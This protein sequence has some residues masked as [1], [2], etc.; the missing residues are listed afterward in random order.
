MIKNNKKALLFTTALLSLSLFLG[1]GCTNKNAQQNP[2]ANNTDTAKEKVQESKGQVNETSQ[3]LT[4]RAQKIAD[5]V[6]KIDG[7]DKAR[8]AISEK[9]AL[10][11]VTIPN[12]AEGKLTDDLKKKVEDTV[13]NTDKEIDTVAVSADADIYERISKIGDGIKDGRGIEEFGNE[14]K[15]LFNRI[16]PQ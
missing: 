2:P 11:G 15:E 10:V 1:T 13:K 5:E 3:N 6:T 12:N 9:R 16:I 7:I 4:N 8:V 14:F